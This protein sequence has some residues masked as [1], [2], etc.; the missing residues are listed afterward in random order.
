MNSLLILVALVAIDPS[1]PEWKGSKEEAA[2]LALHDKEMASGVKFILPAPMRDFEVGEKIPLEIGIRVSD[3]AK[4]KGQT[5]LACSLVGT[6][7]TRVTELKLGKVAEK[8]TVHHQL[9]LDKPGRWVV[10]VSLYDPA[11]KQQISHTS[12]GI[13]IKQR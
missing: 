10:K 8:M 11:S 12:C 4:Y 5:I 1:S 9:V 3:L 6:P 7:F 2:V 13:T